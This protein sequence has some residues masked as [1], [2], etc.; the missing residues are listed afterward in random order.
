MQGLREVKEEAL[1]FVRLFCGQPSTYLW[2]DDDNI[3]HSI[4]QGEE[5][6]RGDPLMPL[7]VI[8]AHTCVKPL[9]RLYVCQCVGPFWVH[10]G[11]W[12]HSGSILDPFWIHFGSILDPFWVYFVVV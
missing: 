11:F 3:V 6:E 10:S 2:E 8:L 9:V 12:I 1:P 4:P 7:R 5:G